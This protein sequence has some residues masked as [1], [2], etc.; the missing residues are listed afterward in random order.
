MDTAE[1]ISQARTKIAEALA[2]INETA[3]SI[4]K[5]ATGTNFVKELNTA[6][7]LYNSATCCNTAIELIDTA[8]ERL[9]KYGKAAKEPVT[10]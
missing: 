10:V 7:Y 4:A 6:G 3:D 8:T 5:E 2:L 1:K 9:A